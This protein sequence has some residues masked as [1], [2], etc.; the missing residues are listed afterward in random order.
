MAQETDISYVISDL[1]SRV[2]ILESRYNL[3]GERLLVINK[4][5]IDEYK[6][7][8]N[9]IKVMD[10]ELKEIKGDVFN[11]K[12][13]IKKIL[14]EISTLAK[15]ENIKV[16]EKYINLWNPMQFVREEDIER[17]VD[18]KIGNF[19]ADLSKSERPI[20]LIGA[21]VRHAKAI[22]ELLELGKDLETMRQLF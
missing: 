2:R 6:K 8:L 1:N 15:K 18:K 11:L 10:T 19:L 17:V 4:N 16:L 9:E 5:M 7:L 22:D 3:L 20:L 14:D 13:T 12:E 21:G